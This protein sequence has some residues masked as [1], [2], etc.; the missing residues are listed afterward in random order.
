MF[1]QGGEASLNYVNLDM[2]IYCFNKIVHSPQNV[3]PLSKCEITFIAPPCW[4]LE[5]MLC[6][7]I[8]LLF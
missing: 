3:K 7:S 8:P 2:Q 5:I 4:K 6:Y 1:K